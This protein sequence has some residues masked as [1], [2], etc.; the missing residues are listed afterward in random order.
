MNA[1]LHCETLGQG[2]PLVLL[3]GWAM[4][5]GLWGPVAEDLAR[6]HRVVLVDLPGHGLSPPVAAELEAWAAAVEA[7]LPPEPV[8]LAGW[9][10]GGLV[11]L[12]LASRLG[13]RIERLALVASNPCFVRRP[14]WPHGVAPELLADFAAALQSDP[15]GTVQR[16][17]A[18]QCRGA[19]GGRETLRVLRAA[20]AARPVPEPAVLAAGLRLLEGTDLRGRLAAL[21][22]PVLFLGGGRDTLV[23]AAALETAAAGVPRARVEVIEGAGH[24]PFL[25]HPEHCA[26]ALEA[27]FA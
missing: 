25:S 14:G 23:P 1:R 10:L 5:G 12:A 26:A 7:V 16:F 17:L 4:H 13:G 20:L 19:D 8:R 22:M 24:A 21:S 9:S 18:L 27:F 3:H 11:A 6:G 15:A 2:P